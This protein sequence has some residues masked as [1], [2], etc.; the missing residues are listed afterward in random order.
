MLLQ[1]FQIL[2]RMIHLEEGRERSRLISRL[3]QFLIFLS[4]LTVVLALP[5]HFFPVVMDTYPLK[6]HC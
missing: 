6:T 1:C 5:W 3:I 4:L 2:L